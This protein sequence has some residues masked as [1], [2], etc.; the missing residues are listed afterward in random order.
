MFSSLTNS[1]SVNVRVFNGFFIFLKKIP[2]GDKGQFFSRGRQSGSWVSPR[3]AWLDFSPGA[4]AVRFSSSSRPAPIAAGYG[5]AMALPV[6]SGM[7]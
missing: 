7:I 5:E 3:V 6:A 2:R 4:G 1:S